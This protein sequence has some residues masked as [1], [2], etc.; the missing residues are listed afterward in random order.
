M[1]RVYE[2]LQRSQG[3]KSNASPLVPDQAEYS[4]VGGAAAALATEPVDATWLNVPP[5][6]VLRPTPTPEQR[7]VTLTEPEGTG[8]EMFRVLATRLA[9]MQNK[10]RL[11]KLLITSS[12]VDEGKSVVAANLA[13]T[14]ARRPNERVLLMEADLRRPTVSALFSSTPLQGVTEWSEGKLPL[15]N[16]L[17][18]LRDSQLWLMASGHALEDPL[19]LLES[20]RFAKMLDTIAQSFDWVLIDATPMFP[21]ADSISLSR[22]CD[23]VLVVVREGFTRRK[24]LNKAVESIDRSKLLGV[25]FNQAS[26]LNVDYNHYYGGYGSSGKSKKEEKKEAK[27]QAKQARDQVKAASA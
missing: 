8:A 22:V 2:A 12:A 5:E 9:H 25:V 23:G 24:V 26:M 19:P 7:L 27:K 13:L 4:A 15:E 20:D 1:S 17:Y 14:L 16:A 3:D 6:R 10:R 21:M 18:Q 11:Q